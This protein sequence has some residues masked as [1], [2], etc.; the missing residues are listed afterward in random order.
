[1]T[2]SASSAYFLTL[3]AHG[4]MLMMTLSDMNEYVMATLPLTGWTKREYIDV[5]TSLTISI[6]LG[7]FGQKI[8]NDSSAGD[9][10]AWLDRL[11]WKK[12]DKGVAFRGREMSL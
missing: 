7:I 6:S 12:Y 1:M 11:F 10:Q 8:W 2:W 5:E 4:T 9:P 3:I